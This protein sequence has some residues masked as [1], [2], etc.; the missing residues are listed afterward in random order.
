MLNTNNTNTNTTMNKGHNSDPP[1][2]NN[3]SSILLLPKSIQ[4]IITKLIKQ[5]QSYWLSLLTPTSKTG[6]GQ[7]YDPSTSTPKKLSKKRKNTTTDNNT[8][9]NTNNSSSVVVYNNDIYKYYMY[10][11]Y[12]SADIIC[13]AAGALTHCDVDT[14]KANPHNS[15][16]HC[17][18]DSNTGIIYVYYACVVQHMMCTLRVYSMM[19]I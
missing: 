10:I 6:H 14:P 7:N 1:T 5:K 3:H 19:C 8:D 9:N 17:N 12:I 2:S 13:M 4:V 15:D 16:H 18:D 11:M